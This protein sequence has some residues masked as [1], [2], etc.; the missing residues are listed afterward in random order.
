[1]RSKTLLRALLPV[2]AGAVAFCATEVWNVKDSSIWTDAEANSILN[3]SPWAKQVKAQ[4]AQ[5]GQARRGGRGMGR[6]GGMG[7][8]GGGYPG[9]GGRASTQPMNV[10]VR[11]ES[12]KPVQEA[13]ARL[14]KLN[15]PSDSKPT[16]G[17]VE[18]GPAANPFETDYVISG[19]GLRGAAGGG[20][21][22][23]NQSDD[24]G[25]DGQ[26]RDQLLTYTQLVMKNKTP[27]SPDDIKVKNLDGGNEIQFFFAKTSPITKDDKEVT[28]KTTIG[29][30]KVENKFELK[31]MT[32]NKK[33]ELD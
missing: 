24:G 21:G 13:E 27:L 29:R 2:W 33:L 22:R 19:I 28:F 4:G 3:K 5:G 11:W 14:R 31:N 1:M 30:M 20:R 15:G 9:G 6:R 10:V 7:Y 32:R 12:A 17:S 16:D 26:V 18:P 23:R 25:S 8:P